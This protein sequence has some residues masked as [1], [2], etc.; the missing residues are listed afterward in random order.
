MWDPPTT[1]NKLW[2]EKVAW[3]MASVRF[4]QERD[5]SDGLWGSNKSD[6]LPRETDDLDRRCSKNPLRLVADREYCCAPGER[7]LFGSWCNVQNNGRGTRG[8]PI[9]STKPAGWVAVFTLQYHTVRGG[10]GFL[11][12][13]TLRCKILRQWRLNANPTATGEAARNS[14]T[15]HLIQCTKW[16]ALSINP[17]KQCKIPCKVCKSLKLS[18]LN[19]TLI[20]IIVFFH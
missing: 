5:S 4:L 2:Y 19:K 18:N 3:E 11:L 12:D 10:N 6:G 16:M 1:Y 9:T 7:L 13:P 14:C 15:C 8:V 20:I 17:T